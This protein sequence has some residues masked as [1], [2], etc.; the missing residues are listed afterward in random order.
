MCALARYVPIA[1]W[2]PSYSWRWL[3]VD[4]PL[5]FANDATARTGIRTLIRR[6]STPPKAVLLDLETSSGL[7]VS[8]ADMLAELADELKA[9]NIA[10]ALARVRTPVLTML[11]RTGLTDTIGKER[12]YP[13]VEAGVEEFAQ[14]SELR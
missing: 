8:S 3:R 10:L 14:Q 6:A 9:M 12:I 2:L 5:F 1:G 7:D 11:T 4:A 13:S